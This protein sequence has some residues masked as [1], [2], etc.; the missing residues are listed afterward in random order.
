MVYMIIPHIC[1]NLEN[2]FDSVKRKIK[3][4]IKQFTQCELTSGRVS[5]K[6]KK[7]LK[8]W[9]QQEKHV[10]MYNF[11]ERGVPQGAH[12]SPK[13]NCKDKTINSAMQLFA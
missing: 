1:N 12:R 8:I 2:A 4:K 11:L 6:K 10:R 7:N 5:K 9:H 3:K 13:S